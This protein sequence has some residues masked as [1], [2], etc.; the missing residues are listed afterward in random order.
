MYG[1]SKEN[2]DPEGEG[3]GE[4][5]QSFSKIYS[6]DLYPPQK[7]VVGESSCVCRCADLWDFYLS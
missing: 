6:S 7:T 3:G 2:E 1:P 5:D 4:E